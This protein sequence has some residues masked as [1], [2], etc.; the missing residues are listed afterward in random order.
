M[1]RNGDDVYFRVPEQPIVV[2]GIRRE[3]FSLIGADHE[4]AACLDL[5]GRVSKRRVY[6]NTSLDALMG[7][8][9][10]PNPQVVPVNA[11]MF[12]ARYQGRTRKELQEGLA[13][14]PSFERYGKSRVMIMY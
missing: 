3:V 8:V 9:V 12:L 13:I 2:E 1:G 6:T 7:K 14:S 4:V 5:I 11:G 10:A